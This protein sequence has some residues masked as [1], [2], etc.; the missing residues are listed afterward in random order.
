[1]QH[2]MFLRWMK[3]Q[4]SLCLNHSR[5]LQNCV[6][7]KMKPVVNEIV[8]RAR[9]ELKQDLGEFLEHTSQGD[10]SGA[11]YW[12]A[13]PNFWSANADCKNRRRECAHGR[14]G[15]RSKSSLLRPRRK[16]RS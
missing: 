5:K 6:P 2:A 14:P 15:C 11:E 16:L 3:T 12:G 10:H 8:E 4:G 9:A 1:M 13:R 7:L